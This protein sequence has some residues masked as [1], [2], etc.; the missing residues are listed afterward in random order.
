MSFGDI[1]TLIL[2]LCFFVY[3]ISVNLKK[4]GFVYELYAFA[5]YNNS[6]VHTFNSCRGVLRFCRKNY[7]PDITFVIHMVNSKLHTIY[8]KLKYNVDS[9][10]FVDIS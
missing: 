3:G 5:P 1:L 2:I 9:D 6:Y 8:R 4:T 10:N 7:N